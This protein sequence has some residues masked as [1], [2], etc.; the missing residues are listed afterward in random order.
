M[1]S[2]QELIIERT[3]MMTGNIIKEIFEKA[4]EKIGKDVFCPVCGRKSEI[5]KCEI[6]PNCP[7]HYECEIHGC[8]TFDM[9]G[10]AALFG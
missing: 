8:F 6:T 2:H 3:D 4:N 10:H 7:K 5:S 9:I 1:C